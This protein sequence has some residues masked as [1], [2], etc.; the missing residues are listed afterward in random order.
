MPKPYVAH[1]KMF[2]AA[3]RHGRHYYWKSHK[4]G[5]L[6]DEIIDVIVPHAEQITS[7]AVAA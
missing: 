3:F 1:Q 6:T 5:P 7:P 2:D 4:L